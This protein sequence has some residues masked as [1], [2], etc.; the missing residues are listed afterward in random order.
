MYNV[1]M[2]D[3]FFTVQVKSGGEGGGGSCYVYWYHLR[4]SSRGGRKEIFLTIRVSFRVACEEINEI[5]NI[6]LQ[7]FISQSQNYCLSLLQWYLCGVKLQW[8][9]I[10]RIRDISNIRP[11]PRRGFVSLDHCNFTLDISNSFY[12]ENPWIY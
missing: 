1:Y 3:V 4:Y 2:V 12:L 10:S 11:V 5:S 8:S 9:P 7:S 6:Y